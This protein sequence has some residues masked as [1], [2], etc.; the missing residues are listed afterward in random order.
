LRD[1]VVAYLV[2]KAESAFLPGAVLLHDEG[3]CGRG[4]ASR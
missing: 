2:A 3:A 1:A 4:R